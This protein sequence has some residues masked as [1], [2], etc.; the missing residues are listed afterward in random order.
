MEEVRHKTAKSWFD[1]LE[2][3]RG[4]ELVSADETVRR[5]IGFIDHTD[6]KHHLINLNALSHTID[7]A[8]GPP[9]SVEELEVQTEPTLR[10][11]IR[12]PEGRKMLVGR[13]C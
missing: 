11:L 6:E 5:S 2:A 3:C 10:G 4:H 12:T 7:E 8:L 13:F 1:Q 9:L